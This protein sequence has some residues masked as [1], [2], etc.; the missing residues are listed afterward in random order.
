MSLKEEMVFVVTAS[1]RAKDL[2]A[3]EKVKE[4]LRT[5]ST[6]YEKDDETISWHVLQHS[7]DTLKFLIVERY[8]NGKSALK[9]HT[10]NPFFKVFQEVLPPLIDGAVPLEYFHEVSKL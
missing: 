6:E 7:K 5:A 8:K 1:I 10:S 4:L 9:Q 3:A 2:A